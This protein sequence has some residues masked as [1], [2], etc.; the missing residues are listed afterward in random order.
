MHQFQFSLLLSFLFHTA[1]FSQSIYS[2]QGFQHGS[3]VAKGFVTLS[4]MFP[5]S[6]NPDSFVVADEY[7]GNV[8]FDA[9]NVHE[10][11]EPFRSRFLERINIQETDSI[12]VY[13]FML[14]QSYSFCVKDIPLMAHLSPY[15]PDLPITTDQYMIGFEFGLKVC[16]MMS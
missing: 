12:F 3:T 7:L 5:Y 4:D 10:L 11:N 13:S 9:D 8:E 16:L 6:Q 14:D 15:G 2:L 1:L